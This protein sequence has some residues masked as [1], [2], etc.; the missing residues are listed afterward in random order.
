MS[1]ELINVAQVLLAVHEIMMCETYSPVVGFVVGF[2]VGLGVGLGFVTG[3]KFLKH[4]L[5]PSIIWLM[6]TQH[7]AVDY[8]KLALYGLWKASIYD[9]WNL[10][11]YGLWNLAFYGLWNLAFY[12][13]WKPSILWLMET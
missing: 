9:L 3:T 1:L 12:G 10:A 8:G 2:L 4:F 7:S 11:F 6:E 5:K 13:L